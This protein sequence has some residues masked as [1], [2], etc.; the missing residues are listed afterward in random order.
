MQLGTRRLD[1]E[2]Q[3]MFCVRSDEL[4]RKSGINEPTNKSGKQLVNQ[5]T[6]GNISETTNQTIR[7]SNTDLIRKSTS[8]AGYQCTSK[9]ITESTNPLP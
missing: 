1:S 8:Q 6:N 4:V 7:E 9:S 3:I 2:H 5:P